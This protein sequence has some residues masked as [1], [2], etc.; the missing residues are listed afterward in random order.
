MSIE[1]TRSASS[2]PSCL[3]YGV[4]SHDPHS[5]YLQPATEIGTLA[6]PLEARA[7]AAWLLPL[8]HSSLEICVVGNEHGLTSA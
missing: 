8:V 5:E 2:R 4:H 3:E 7:L 1:L 6:R